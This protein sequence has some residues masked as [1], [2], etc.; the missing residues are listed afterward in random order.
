MN[1]T[2]E[3]YELTKINKDLI[4]IIEGYLNTDYKQEYEYVMWEFKIFI[5]DSAHMYISYQ[6]YHNLIE[7]PIF[8]PNWILKNK[9]Y[10]TCSFQ[11]D[12]SIEYHSPK[13]SKFSRDKLL[14][15]IQEKY[16]IY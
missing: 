8:N 4:N 3:I 11:F 9:F 15:Q 14:H 13:W 1:R 5:R 6:Y 7:K 12:N 16:Y 2:V 10:D